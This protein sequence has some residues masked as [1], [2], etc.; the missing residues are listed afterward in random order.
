MKSSSIEITELSALPARP[1]DAHKGT[2]G[3]VLV[4]A[5]STGMSG[6]GALAALAA[7]RSGAG[8][9]TMFVPARIYKIAASA[10]PCIMTH[11]SK[12][13]TDYFTL[14]AMDEL[15]QLLAQANVVALGPGLGR[16]EETGA[17]VRELAMRASALPLVLDADGLYGVRGSVKMLAQRKAQT[18]LTPHPGERS[19]LDGGTIADIQPNRIEAADLLAEMTGG[20]CV[21]KGHRT[22]VSNGQRHYVNP[23]GNAGMATA[24]SGDVLTGVIAG[25]IAQGMEPFGASCLATCLHG[26]AGD[27]AAEEFGQPSLIATDLIDYLPQAFKARSHSS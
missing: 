11:P 2:F 4:V 9:V 17:F 25:L 12:A 19:Y 5:G 21:L 7:L 18:V 1:V 8:L 10:S 16:N 20:V 27:L 26:L 14:E 3:R 24:G 15:Q 22:V 23:T 6:A 13:C